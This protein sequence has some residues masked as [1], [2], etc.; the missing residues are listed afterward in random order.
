MRANQV[1][2]GRYPAQACGYNMSAGTARSSY[3]LF[4]N[5]SDVWFTTSAPWATCGMDR[6]YKLRSGSRWPLVIRDPFLLK[7]YTWFSLKPT[8]YSFTHILLTESNGNFTST[9]FLHVCASLVIPLRGNQSV[10][11]KC[12]IDPF[13]VP[14]LWDIVLVRGASPFYIA[15]K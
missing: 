2:F 15:G 5:S 10:P 8:R 4:A 6:R 13:A 1:S 12:I 14:T 3:A 7:I 9:N 11:T